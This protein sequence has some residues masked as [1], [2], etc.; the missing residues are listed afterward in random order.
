MR[1]SSGYGRGFPIETENRKPSLFLF[2]HQLRLTNLP[3]AL[4]ILILMK[5]IYIVGFMG[6]GKTAV[7]KL[8]AK[9]LGLEFIEMDELI[10]QR[11]G[12]KIVDIFAQDGEGAFRKLESELLGELSKR[13]DLVIS[14]GGGLICEEVNLKLLRT[15]G[16]VFC[17]S[18]SSSTIYERTKRY[19]HRP[20]L[21]VDK[22]LEKIEKLLAA[23]EPYYSQA[24]HLIDSNGLSVDEVADKIINIL[25]QA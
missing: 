13:Q 20:L 12:R 1:G 6:T 18:A 3:I 10:E 24:H 7:G 15:S 4:I 2:S 5:N 11:Q 21:N 14:C 16:T 19:S 23:R 8:L 25:K 9:R 17:L 22:P